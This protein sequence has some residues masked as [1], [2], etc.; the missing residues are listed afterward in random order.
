MK[1]LKQVVVETYN[2]KINKDNLNEYLNKEGMND[3][4]K[5]WYHKKFK[6]DELWEEIDDIITFAD[7]LKR[8]VKNQ[9]D[10]YNIL[11]VS[12]SLVRERVFTAISKL[13]KVPYDELY[14]RWLLNE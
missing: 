6:T 9:E 12:D 13:C 14:E 5:Q 7:V 3:N 4:V 1:R 2:F 8:M 11:N 10:I